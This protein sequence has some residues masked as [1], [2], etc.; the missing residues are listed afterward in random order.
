MTKDNYLDEVP[1]AF[2]ELAC[3]FA[4]TGPLD[5]LGQSIQRRRDGVL[6]IV[7][8]ELAANVLAHLAKLVDSDQLTPGQLWSAIAAERG[9]VGACNMLANL[10][11]AAHGQLIEGA[12]N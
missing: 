5:E 2:N 6:E 4:N 3:Q 8:G 9:S 11:R 10:S 1:T 7:A 12:T